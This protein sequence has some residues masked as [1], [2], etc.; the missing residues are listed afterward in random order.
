[1]NFVEP[2]LKMILGFLGVTDVKFV[3]AAGAA[4]VMRGTV[5]RATFLQPVLEQVRTVSA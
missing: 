5:D 2:Y 3:N 1:M 4:Q